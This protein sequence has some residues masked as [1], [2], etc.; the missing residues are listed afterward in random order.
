MHHCF[1]FGAAR[2]FSE[3]AAQTRP[4]SY[5]DP[6]TNVHFTGDKGSEGAPLKAVSAARAHGDK[7]VVG[8]Q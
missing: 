2:D 4:V 5:T 8:T 7:E 3:G 1:A 6:A